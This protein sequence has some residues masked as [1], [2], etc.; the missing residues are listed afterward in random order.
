MSNIRFFTT[1]SGRALWTRLFSTALLL[2]CT[3]VPSVMAAEEPSPSMI[4]AE[5]GSRSAMTGEKEQTQ[6]FC[7]VEETKD[8]KGEPTGVRTPIILFG[9]AAKD[10]EEQA[11]K[12]RKPPGGCYIVMTGGNQSASGFK[13]LDTQNQ[14]IGIAP[15]TATCIDGS[16][17]CVTP[18][19]VCTR[20]TL[21][22]SVWVGDPNAG[23]P[24]N[25]GCNCYSN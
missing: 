25:C 14:V 20:G 23:G 15:P 1:G 13:A 17:V 8:K 4:A 16:S 6:I 9:K 2:G 10:A 5:Q 22:K 21:C 19:A 7:L 12:Q 18:G 24:G 11:K 3:I